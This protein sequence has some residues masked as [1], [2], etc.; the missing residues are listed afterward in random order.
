MMHLK[1]LS[2]TVKEQAVVVLYFGSGG[3]LSDEGFPAERHTQEHKVE[4]NVYDKSAC[5]MSV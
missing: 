2:F 5:P 3:P 4:R 1:K